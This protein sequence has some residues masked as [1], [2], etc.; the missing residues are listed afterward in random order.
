MAQAQ[1]REAAAPAQVGGGDPRVVAHPAFREI[2]RC[3]FPLSTDEARGEYDTVARML[4]DAGRLTAGAHRTL[5]SYAMQF[6]AITKAA[7]EGKQVRGSWFAN[8]D[9]ARSQL[10][11][12]DIDKPIAAPREAPTNRYARVG[13][14]HR[15][16]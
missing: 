12:D 8:L 3:L 14:A 10:G 11:I 16:R 5:S 15:R 4:F 1:R 9:K 2:P 6:D 13:F 7:A